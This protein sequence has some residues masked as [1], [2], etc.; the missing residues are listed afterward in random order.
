M[1]TA[2]DLYGAMVRDQEG[3]RL[4]RVHEIHAVS[5]EVRNLTIGPLGLLQRFGASRAG[6]RVSWR[7]VVRVEN[8]SVIV[9][10]LRG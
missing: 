10:G 9:R 1:L 4:G 7:T 3:R 8:G 2:S 6:R 5:G